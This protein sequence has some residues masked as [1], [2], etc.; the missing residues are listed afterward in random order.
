MKFTVRNFRPADF[1]PLWQIDQS[2][3][4]PEIAYSQAELKFYIQRKTS[5]TLVAEAEQQAFSETSKS[6]AVG[7]VV[8]DRSSRIGHVITIDVVA[9]VRG[10][11]VGAALLSA[12]EERLK[13]LECDTVRLETAVDNLAALRFY[14]KHGY[15]VHKAVPR[16]YSNGVDA[17]LLQ[18]DLLSP[19]SSE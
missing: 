18:K 13:F 10:H 4:S 9:T 11:G 1:L 5:F 15:S 16:Y 12:A 7:F 8:A 3:F 6:D 14:K 17:L 19:S 2:C